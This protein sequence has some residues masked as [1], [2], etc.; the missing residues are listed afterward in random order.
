M[1]NESDTLPFV[2]P[3]AAEGSAVLQACPGNFFYSGLTQVEV[4]VCLTYGARTMLGIDSPA[5]PGWA[6]QFGGRPYGP[7]NLDRFLEKHFQER[8]AELQIPRLPRVSC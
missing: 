7:Q 8:S 5:L 2:I 3:S 4:E 6:A 1:L